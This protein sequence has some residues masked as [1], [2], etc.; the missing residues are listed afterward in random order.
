M[1][2][3]CSRFRSRLAD[4]AEGNT[5]VELAEH[6]G[7][8]TVCSQIISEYKTIFATASGLWE[9]APLESIQLAKALMPETRRVLFAKRLSVGAAATARGPQE[10]FQVL[11]GGEDISMRLMATPTTEG[12]SIR[13]KVPNAD[14]IVYAENAV[15]MPD[16]RFEFTVPTLEDSS[17][18][19]LGEDTILQVPALSQLMTYDSD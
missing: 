11:V 9:S 17:F 2:D 13:G 8:C 10:E 16:G 12:W 4:A 19:V 7:Q 3:T 14:W 15:Q 1:R 6:L 18:D 5:N